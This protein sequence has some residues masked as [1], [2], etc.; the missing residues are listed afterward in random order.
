MIKII[1]TE[2]F[3]GVAVL[4][5]EN[6][7]DIRMIH[8]NTKLGWLIDDR[9]F[10]E[11]LLPYCNYLILGEANELAEEQCSEIVEATVEIL[12]WPINTDMPNVREVTSRESFKKLLY[13]IGCYTLDAFNKPP[14]GKW[15]ILKKINP[16]ILL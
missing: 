9:L 5:P 6:A 16:I 7:K 4:A 11:T 3:E 10:H 2:I 15:M 14:Q 1:K 13:K 8:H 12:D